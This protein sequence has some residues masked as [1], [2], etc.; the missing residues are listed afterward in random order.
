MDH[1]KKYTATGVQSSIEL[2]RDLGWKRGNQERPMRLFRNSE[3]ILR[4]KVKIPSCLLNV[5]P[6]SQMQYFM[7]ERKKEKKRKKEEP[8]SI[9]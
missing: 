4:Y 5:S 3:V 2:R 9:L 6:T 8:G 1:F 7:D